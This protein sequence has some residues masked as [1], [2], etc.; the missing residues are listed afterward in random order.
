MK[1]TLLT[2]ITAFITS[3]PLS[4]F[5][6]ES[7]NKDPDVQTSAMDLAKMYGDKVKCE[8]SSE[9]LVYLMTEAKDKSLRCR[10]SLILDVLSTNNAL[11]VME[12]VNRKADEAENKRCE[13]KMFLAKLSLSQWQPK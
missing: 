6:A 9:Q 12:K 8:K 3:L 11:L 13:D 5:A 1:T 10:I 2:I 4:G 7:D